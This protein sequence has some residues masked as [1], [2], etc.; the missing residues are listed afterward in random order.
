MMPFQAEAR[1]ARAREAV[2]EVVVVEDDT[3]PPPLFLEA[4][5]ALSAASWLLMRE[6]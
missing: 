3:L 4:L 1:R 6:G 5:S 2:V